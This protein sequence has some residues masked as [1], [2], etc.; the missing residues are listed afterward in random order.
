MMKLKWHTLSI[1][2]NHPLK[3][4][5]IIQQSLKSGSKV[6]PI[7]FFDDGAKK[8]AN[9]EFDGPWETPIITLVEIAMNKQSLSFSLIRLIKD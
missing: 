7:Q 5:E 6:N 3:F 2:Q 4:C 8:D 9:E 1:S